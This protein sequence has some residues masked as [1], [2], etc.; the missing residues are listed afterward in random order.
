LARRR[1]K[2]AHFVWALNGYFWHAKL[3]FS[4]LPC[5]VFVL[6]FALFAVVDEC[7]GAA[8]AVL[9]P[10]FYFFGLFSEV[11]EGV[12]IYVY[13]ESAVVAYEEAVFAP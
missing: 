11:V 9:F 13:S 2:I 12:S 6:L 10:F 3:L 5:S 1:K 8:G 7:A 4:S